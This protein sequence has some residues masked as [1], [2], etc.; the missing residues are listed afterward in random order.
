MNECE[1]SCPKLRS[2][3]ATNYF[4]STTKNNIVILNWTSSIAW[5]VKCTEHWDLEWQA[6]QSLQRGLS[7][8]KQKLKHS[9]QIIQKLAH[10]NHIQTEE[11]GK[12]NDAEH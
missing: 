8:F 2:Y 3:N 4:L 7:K 10:R 1:K 5:L 11:Q 6:A 9:L 12:E